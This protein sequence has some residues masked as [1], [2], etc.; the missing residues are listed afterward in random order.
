MAEQMHDL[1]VAFEQLD[2]CSGQGTSAFRLFRLRRHFIVEAAPHMLGKNDL[3]HRGLAR[4]H[5]QQPTI[6]L[7]WN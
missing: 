5:E 1:G 2:A 4:D 3:Q 7:K 6:C